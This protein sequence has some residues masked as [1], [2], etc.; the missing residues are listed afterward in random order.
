MQLKFEKRRSHAYSSK[1]IANE[2]CGRY[3]SS[4]LDSFVSKYFDVLLSILG[5]DAVIVIIKDYLDLLIDHRALHLIF[6]I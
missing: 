6:N 1:L 5:V 4:K 2:S 3:S